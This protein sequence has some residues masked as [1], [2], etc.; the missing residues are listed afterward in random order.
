MTVLNGVVFP[1][2]FLYSLNASSINKHIHLRPGHRVKIGRSTKPG[3]R[4]NLALSRAHAEVWEEDGKIFIQDIKSSNGTFLNS[5]RLSPKGTESKPFQVKTGDILTFGSDIVGKDRKTVVHHKVAARVFCIFT[6]EDAAAAAAATARSEERQVA[7][8]A[9]YGGHSHRQY[10]L[11]PLAQRNSAASVAHAKRVIVSEPKTFTLSSTTLGN[12]VFNQREFQ[13]RYCIP[14]ELANLQIDDPAILLN[15]LNEIL[16]TRYRFDT[17]PALEPTLRYCISRTYNLGMVYGLLRPWWLTIADNTRSFPEHFV[18]LERE[19]SERRERAVFEGLIIKRLMPP[20]RVWD[21]YSNRILP[22]WALDESV[23]WDMN[24]AVSPSRTEHVLA[25]SHAWMSPEQRMG[26][27]TAINGN[28]WP[29]PLPRDINLDDLRIELLNLRNMAQY[30]WLDVLCLRQGYDAESVLEKDLR[31]KEWKIDV[32]TIGTIYEHCGP[33]VVYLNGLARP[34]EENDISSDRHWCN[35]AW[36]M[37]EWCYASQNRM[38]VSLGGV[39]EQSPMSN[40][41]Q[42]YAF[43]Q[44]VF[45]QQLRERMHDTDNCVRRIITAAAMM[46]RRRAEGEIDKIAG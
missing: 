20:R 31:E 6:L 29:V 10:R 3:R 15:E 26:V 36:T 41:D 24:V 11:L 45:V 35:R 18:K 30:A 23:Y 12:R 22:F 44:T 25:V 2:L 32:P 42:L 46:S 14:S 4:S 21:L 37:Q 38:N 39:T 8:S 27:L 13:C 1:T 17:I 34:F 5:M 7:D 33:A 43:P 16:G 28:Q 9:F 40:I 19:D